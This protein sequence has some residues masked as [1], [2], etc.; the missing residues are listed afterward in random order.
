MKR[1]HSISRRGFL[2]SACAAAGLGIVAVPPPLI[3]QTPALDSAMGRIPANR[4]GVQIYTLRNLLDEHMLGFEGAFELLQDIGVTNVELAGLFMGQTPAELRK[5]AARYGIDIA[6][7][8]FGPRTMDGANPWY[9][10]AGRAAIF[11]DARA[12]GL[13]F[14]G[15]GHYYNVPL[16]VDGFRQ[17]AQ[18][19]NVW[20]KAASEV[21]LKFY[22]HNH[23]GEFARYNGRPIFD[24]LLEETDPEHVHFEL[25]L[26]WAAIA[27]EDIYEFVPRHQHRF[28]LFHVKDFWFVDDG[29]RET[30]PNTLAAGNRFTFADVGK[31]T[32]DWP[33]LLSG[34]ENPS[35]HLYFIER[36]DAGVDRPAEGSPKPTNPAGPVNTVWSS[37]RYLTELEY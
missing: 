26:A 8:H 16:T 13:E 30:K 15:T 6:G 27:G 31:G 12:L 1:P 17:F 18:T 25:D 34:L 36:D 32:I 19:L 3:A 22:Y 37:F 20:G 9:D 10:A 28:P 14:V 4:V 35:R 2:T 29:P 11:A 24:I 21:G 5:M 23:D 33:R 7:N